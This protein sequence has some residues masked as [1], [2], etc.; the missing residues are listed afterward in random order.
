MSTTAN[1]QAEGDMSGL[2]RWSRVAAMIL[3]RLFT[4]GVIVQVFLAGLGL[5]ESADYWDDHKSLGQILG[6]I[7]V[8]LIVT[9]IIGRLPS[10]LIGMSVVL[11]VLWIVQY[12]LP[13]ADNGY[14][15]ALHPLNAFLLLGLSV[16]IGDQI[17]NLTRSAASTKEV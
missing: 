9:A 15:A 4:M 11:L 7:P 14:I 3:A 17:R 16:Q 1:I 13:K 5:F 2:P 10:R 12:L 6:I 8:L